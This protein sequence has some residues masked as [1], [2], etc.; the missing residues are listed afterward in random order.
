MSEHNYSMGRVLIPSDHRDWVANFV[1]GYRR[2]GF[3][4][5]TGTYN[6]ELEACHPDVVHFQWPEELTGWKLP[7]S[8]QIDDITRRLDRWARRSRLIISVN[9]LYPHGQQGN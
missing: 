7:T 9:N 6:F 1:D 5:T 3:D 8:A 4:V 2:L